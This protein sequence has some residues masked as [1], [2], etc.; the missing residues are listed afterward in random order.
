MNSKA[1]AYHAIH[2]SDLSVAV[3]NVVIQSNIKNESL[4]YM[5][6]WDLWFQGESP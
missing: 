3:I 4:F 5:F 1:R 2:A 6:I